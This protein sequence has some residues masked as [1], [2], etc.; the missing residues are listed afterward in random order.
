MPGLPWWARLLAELILLYFVGRCAMSQGFRALVR[1][2]FRDFLK[3]VDPAATQ[4]DRDPQWGGTQMTRLRF[5]I[6][7]KRRS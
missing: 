2:K 5:H 6:S 3:D 7:P 4:R 1:R